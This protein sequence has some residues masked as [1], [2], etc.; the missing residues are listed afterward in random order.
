MVEQ[1]LWYCIEKSHTYSVFHMH[2]FDC[3]LLTVILTFEQY[4]TSKISRIQKN[5]H[6]YL[7]IFCFVSL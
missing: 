4:Q 6:V 2:I 1:T 5:G 3:V 7:S